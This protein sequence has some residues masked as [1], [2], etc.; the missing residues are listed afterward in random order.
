MQYQ[1]GSQ[2]EQYEADKTK[3]QKWHKMVSIMAA[4]VV[5]ATCYALVL[6]AI[7]MEQPNRILECPLEVHQHEDSCYE[8]GEEK[9]LICGK[10]DYVLH[11]HGDECFDEEGVLVCKIPELSTEAARKTGVARI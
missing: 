9:T 1:F 7:T 2:F 5:L 3:K 6:P 10:A 8:Q 11:C 4:F